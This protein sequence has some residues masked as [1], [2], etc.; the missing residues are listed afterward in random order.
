MV[1]LSSAVQKKIQTDHN[2]QQKCKESDRETQ[3]KSPTGP[4]LFLTQLHAW[5]SFPVTQAPSGPFWTQKGRPLVKG[6][7]VDAA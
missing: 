7:G 4:R 2:K 6:W 3:L 5:V 1:S